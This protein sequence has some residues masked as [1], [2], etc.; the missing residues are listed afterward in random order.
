MKTAN[1]RQILVDKLSQSEVGD[2]FLCKTM[3]RGGGRHAK[4]VYGKQGERSGINE[5]T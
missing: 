1:Y 2:L 5:Q 3:T 4:K